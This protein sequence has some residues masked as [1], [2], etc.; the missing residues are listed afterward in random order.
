[1][2]SSREPLHRLSGLVFRARPHEIAEAVKRRD[3][4]I[5]LCD[6]IDR[7]NEGSLMISTAKLAS[8]AILERD[9]RFLLVLRRNPPSA[10][11]YAF[12]GG[13]AEPGETPEQTA[14]REF[15]E[16]TGISAHNPR[17][18]STYDLKTHGPDGSIRSH[19][20]LSVFCVDADREMVAEAADDAAALGWYTVEEIRRLPVPQSVLECAERLASGE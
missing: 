15:R 7:H 10:D 9:G 12:P 5:G 4:T 16:E 11:M 1:M 18:F 17:L 8:S 6:R 20:F 3:A 13:R 2:S 14:L 19:F